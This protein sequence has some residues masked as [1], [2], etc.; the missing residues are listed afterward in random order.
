MESNLSKHVRFSTVV[1]VVALLLSSACSPSNR[2]P[3]KAAA[4]M[5]TRRSAVVTSVP[6]TAVNLTAQRMT[7]TLRDGTTVPMWGYCVTGTCTTTWAPGPTIMATAGTNLLINLTNTLPVPTSLVVLGQLGGGLG[8]PTTM[9]S[10]A[11][12][13]QNF[14]TFPGN[15]QVNPTGPPAFQ[16]PAQGPRV[17]SFGTEIPAAGST[18]LTWSNLKPGTYIYETGTLPSLEVPMGL[19][20]LLVVTSAAPANVTSTSGTCSVTTATA[21]LTSATCPAG[22]TC[23]ITTTTSFAAGTA[24]PGVTYDADATL[25]FSEIDPVQN[26]AVDAAAV[27]GTDVNK[28]FNDPSCTPTAPCYPAAVNYAPTYFMINGAWFD[29]TSPQ[30]STITV[31]D[32]GTTS[33][34]SSGNILLRLANAGSRTHIPTFVGLPMAL[35]AEDGNLAPGLPKVQNEVLLTAG[36]TYDAL[37]KPAAAA[38]S[39]AYASGNLPGLRPVPG[40]EHRQQA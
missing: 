28:R 39:T 35:V 24:Y 15:A 25:L 18:A 10:P 6:G 33:T 16:P 29:R 11:H 13:G 36:K 31:A 4:P 26:A 30:N 3:V 20:G 8:T 12:P 32:A 19:Y 7:T 17:R 34:F 1:G 27:A 21:C 23:N 2:A 38:G 14:T 9:P 37:V 22:E 40:P 5:A